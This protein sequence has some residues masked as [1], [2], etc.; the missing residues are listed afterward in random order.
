MKLFEHKIIYL[1][2]EA[3]QVQASSYANVTIDPITLYED[4]INSNIQRHSQL[5]FS[6]E[7]SLLSMW[8][9]RASPK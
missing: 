5:D 1:E 3:T 2:T 6:Q 9:S 4:A 7:E 8:R